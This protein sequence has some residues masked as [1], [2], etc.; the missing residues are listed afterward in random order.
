MARDSRQDRRER[1]LPGRNVSGV[2]LGALLRAA[3]MSF[4]R[5]LRDELARHNITFGQFQHLWQ[6]FAADGIAQV[7]LSRLV[8]IETASSTAVIEQLE[9]L[10]FIRRVR[11]ADDRRRI[12]VSLTP[13]GWALEAPLTEAAI[14]VNAMARRGL[15]AR[16]LNTLL[17]Y[18]EQ[19]VRN[20]RASTE[21]RHACSDRSFADRS[22][23]RRGR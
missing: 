21:E 14:G 4:N 5:L 20:L 22:G 13:A 17:Q 12:V 15:R 11:A 18:L 10:G 23:T 9:K 8:G 7:E 3:D 6:L 16:D 2:G 1:V 19:V